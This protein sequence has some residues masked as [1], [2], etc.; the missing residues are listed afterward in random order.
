MTMVIFH[1]YSK[2]C[3]KTDI[4]ARS[5]ADAAVLVIIAAAARIQVIN[6]K[7]FD[8]QVSKLFRI[9]ARLKS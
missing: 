9:S 1:Y 8:I 6:N 3:Y 4:T 2:F 5:P 7:T